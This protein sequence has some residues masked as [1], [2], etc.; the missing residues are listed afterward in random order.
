MRQIARLA[1]VI[2]VM[3]VTNLVAAPHSFLPIE[4]TQPDGSRVDIYASGDEFHN[5][6]HDENNYT[7]MKD[8]SGA[9]VYAIQERGSL[10][11]SDL[12]VG[13][14]SPNVRSIAPG[15]NLSEDK[16]RAKY[17]RLETMRDYSNGRAPHTGLINN[18]VIF[19]KFDGSPDF[20][21]QFNTY[22]FIFNASGTAHNSMKRY[23][24]AVSYNQLD[25]DSYF[26]PA[27]N[28]TTVACYTDS[29]PRSYYQPYSASN[30]YGYANDTER[31]AREHL[32]LKNAVDAVSSQ[33]SPDLVIDG[34]GDGYVDNVCFIVQGQVDGWNSLLWPHRWVLSG[35]DA[36]IHDKQVWDYNFQLERSLDSSGAS[37]L[38][39][40]MFHSLGAPDLYRYENPFIVPVGEWDLMG[41]NL[42]PPQH[43]S[44][45]M[46]H[47]YHHHIRNLYPVPCGFFLH[48]QYLPHQ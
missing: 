36:Y 43:T 30:T 25:V 46:K 26:Y 27:P 4:A 3:V 31:K 11:P 1:I 35:Q 45:W 10:V 47:R 17:E 33:I 29:E 22:H 6:L 2:M 14:D 18:V 37:V 44:V 13:R 7:I 39:H 21:T 41:H 9:Y 32:L 20:T 16:I 34:D 42:K 5:W 19:I 8:E 12:L 40:E 15:L 38:S 24:Q 28:G 48:Q 23:F